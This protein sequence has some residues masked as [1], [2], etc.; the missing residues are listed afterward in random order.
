MISIKPSTKAYLLD[1]TTYSTIN[2][3][4]A[5]SVHHRVQLPWLLMDPVLLPDWSFI[6][7]LSTVHGFQGRILR[8]RNNWPLEIQ[9]IT[10]TGPFSVHLFDPTEVFL[11]ESR[12]ITFLNVF[13][14]LEEEDG[15]EMVSFKRTFRITNI[16][17]LTSEQC[18]LQANFITPYALFVPF[19]KLY[20]I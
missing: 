20:L 12:S 7:C 13:F 15:N 14:V 17:W 5:L 16:C 2:L 9:H 18:S 10:Y 8:V 4:C 1:A 6:K 19:H 3:F 11:L